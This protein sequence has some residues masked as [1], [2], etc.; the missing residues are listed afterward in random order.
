MKKL[1]AVLLS[2]GLLLSASA[3]DF[4]INDADEN[5]FDYPVTVGNIRSAFCR[6]GGRTEQKENFRIGHRPCDRR[7]E[8]RPRL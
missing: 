4:I 6:Y 1:F 3:C 8:Y 5:R 2:A 7:R